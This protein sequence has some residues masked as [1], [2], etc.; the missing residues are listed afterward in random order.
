MTPVLRANLLKASLRIRTL[1]AEIRD[2]HVIVP[3]DVGKA[4]TELCGIIDVI[5]LSDTNPDAHINK[6]ADARRSERIRIAKLLRTAGLDE[7]ATITELS[8]YGA[9]CEKAGMWIR[10]SDGIVRCDS[11]L[12]EE[13][14]DGTVRCTRCHLKAA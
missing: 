6:A 5:I 12:D 1:A 14:S 7:A 4:L 3:S 2:Q 13:D 11:G 8:K 9:E 10:G